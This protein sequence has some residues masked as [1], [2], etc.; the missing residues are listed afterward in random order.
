MNH[1]LHAL[2]GLK[3]NPFTAD[4]PTQALFMTPAIDN[5][6]WRIEN[7]HIKEGGFALMTGDPG[8][9][10][11]CLL[12]LLAE[13]LGQKKGLS[14][15]TFTH[16][17][18][19]ISD[20]YHELGD[21]FDIALKF[22]NRWHSFKSLRE[23]W[24]THIE[25]NA[26]KPVLL[27]DEAQEMQTNVMNE[28]RLLNSH[29]YDST[30]L[31]TVIFSG[32]KSLVDRLR[33][34]SSLLPLGSRI[35]KRLLMEHQ[36]SEQLINCLNHLLEKAGNHTLMSEP[37]IQMICDHCL[38]NYRIMASIANELLEEACHQELPHLDEKLYFEVFN[39]STKNK[40]N[41]SQRGK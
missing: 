5:F 12:R 20:F 30:N 22:N 1:Q 11:S 41:S 24:Q 10:K 28:L 32:N 31:L 23:K 6:I 13:K 33:T 36:T 8:T 15:G 19:S 26:I 25:N 37:L 18:S 40:S 14:V 21:M 39:P 17:Q 9:G 16:P 2:Y 38:G 4:L 7:S 34:N 3:F 35:T 27:I 29:R